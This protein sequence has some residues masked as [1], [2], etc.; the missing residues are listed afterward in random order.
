MN[1][2]I[3]KSAECDNGEI[4]VASALALRGEI[5]AIACN[6]VESTGI[7]WHHAEFLVIKRTLEILETRYLEYADLYVTLEPCAFCAS[8]L[9]KVRISSIFFGAYDPKCGAIVHNIRLFDHSL[10][11]PTIIGGIQEPICSHIL[12]RFFEKLRGKR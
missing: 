2:V 1:A 5:I 12:R 6:E 7:P 9:E 3:E 4:P 10:V 8:V 11:K